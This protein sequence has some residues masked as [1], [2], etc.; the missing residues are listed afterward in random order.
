[1]SLED[2]VI[3]AAQ[4]PPLDNEPW[5]PIERAYRSVLRWMVFI[6]CA[7]PLIGLGVVIWFNPDHLRFPAQIA[8][9]VVVAL[10]LFLMGVWVPRRVAH[11]QYI[12]REQDVHKRTGFW[13]HKTTSAGHNRI[14]HIEVI[15]G[16]IERLYGLSQLALY[17][18]GGFQ[19]DVRIPGLK[20]DEAHRLKQ[21]LT[22]RIVSEEPVESDH[23]EP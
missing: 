7:I 20:T 23:G 9:G 16:P 19:S 15:Q 14:Q 5:T 2:S 22:Q 11:T 1:M 10:A 8:A 6:W 13:W 3:T 18:A 12:L 17:T 4:L 21:Y